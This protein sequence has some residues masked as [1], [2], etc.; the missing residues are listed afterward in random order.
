MKNSS[1]HSVESDEFYRLEPVRQVTAHDGM[2]RF[3][4]PGE[5]CCAI[6][7]LKNLGGYGLGW[8]SD[9]VEPS[10][11]FHANTSVLWL[12]V[13]ERAVALNVQTGR[14]EASLKLDSVLFDIFWV[15]GAIAIVC[16]LEVL[17]LNAG[18]SL[19]F[20]QPL[21]DVVGGAIVKE[22]QLI[23][24]TLENQN[25]ELDIHQGELRELVKAA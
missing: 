15:D 9:L 14:V 8:S 19:R 13:D 23:L 4:I 12:G 16:E 18:A 22:K 2:Q 1:L 20:I 5:V 10:L 3:A 7:T 21:P 25:F 17:V 24:E 11:V 6:A